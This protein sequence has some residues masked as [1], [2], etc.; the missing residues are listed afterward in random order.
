MVAKRI[1]V[2]VNVADLL[3]DERRC[4]QCQ[5]VQSF[6]TFSQY[7]GKMTERRGICYECESSN[8]FERHRR[9]ILQRERWHQ[10]HESEERKLQEWQRK[11]ALRQV[12]ERR[13]QEWEYWYRQQADRRCRACEDLLPAS[14]FGRIF[15]SNGFM[16]HTRCIRCHAALREHHQLACC[17]CQQ[18]T[19]RR[20]FL[21]SYN[22]YALCGN[23]TCISLCCQSCEVAFCSLSCH[24]QWLCI[25]AC[26]QRAFP[27]GQVI[28]SEVDPET[29]DIRY[30]GRTSKPK[31]RHKQHLED[32]SSRIREWGTQR[33]M[34]YTRSNWMYALSEKGLEPSMCILQTVDASPLV[35]EWELRYIWHGIQQ[36][37]RLLNVETMDERLVARVKESRFNFL[38]I[39]FEVLVQ[40]HFF[41]PSGLVAFLHTFSV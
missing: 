9:M 18:K 30:I 37:W 12:H 22:G 8:Q 17:L 36:G 4:L 41:S 35:V 33:T 38:E 1:G 40:Q 2:E 16:L 11:V 32:V 26:C 29:G 23:G 28:Y 39:P 15:S 10:Q 21:A 19:A 20:D 31:R 3:E 13:Q 34:W 25:Q 7:K 5:K 14:A 24:Q 27:D 6:Q